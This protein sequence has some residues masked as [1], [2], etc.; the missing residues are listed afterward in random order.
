MVVVV[1]VEGDALVVAADDER[2]DGVT[3]VVDGWKERERKGERGPSSAIEDK[4]L[5]GDWKEKHRRFERKCLVLHD[6]RDRGRNPY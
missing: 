3:V 5:V 2:K 4:S 1:V 6:S